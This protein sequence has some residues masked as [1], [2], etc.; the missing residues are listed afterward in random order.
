MSDFCISGTGVSFAWP[1][2]SRNDYMI[3]KNS[4]PLQTTTIN[5][6]LGGRF[7]RRNK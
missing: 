4:D 6:N 5:K 3:D 7:Q 1:N 2:V